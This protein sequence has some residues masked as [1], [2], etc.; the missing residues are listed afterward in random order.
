MGLYDDIF[1]KG[2]EKAGGGQIKSLDH[3]DELVDSRQ[4]NL[5]N[6]DQK[7]TVRI[8]TGEDGKTRFEFSYES[9]K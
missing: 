7:P 8:V 6:D 2:S 4:D 9:Q 5:I 1:G 3:L